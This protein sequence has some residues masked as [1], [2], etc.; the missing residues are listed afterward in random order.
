[1]KIKT[2]LSLKGLNRIRRCTPSAKCMVS[3]V[4]IRL[5][6]KNVRYIRIRFVYS[7]L[8]TVSFRRTHSNFIS[9]SF[10]FFVGLK[11]RSRSE[12]SWCPYIYSSAQFAG[13]IVGR[14]VF[15]TVERR[16][17]RVS[18]HQTIEEQAWRKDTG[19]G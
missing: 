4:D 10:F 18:C 6:L 12:L 5:V 1:M 19:G 11:I 2:R 13:E 14:K 15:S 8:S 7:H 17:S 3:S 9:G 16:R